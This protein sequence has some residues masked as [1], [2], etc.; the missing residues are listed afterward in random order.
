MHTWKMCVFCSIAIKESVWLFVGA[1]LRSATTQ[2]L[3]S[4][5]SLRCF[6]HKSH[7]IC[8]R[9]RMFNKSIRISSKEY[10]IYNV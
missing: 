7:L 6:H 2:N 9:A 4:A 3:L 1:F 8:T 10:S 5:L